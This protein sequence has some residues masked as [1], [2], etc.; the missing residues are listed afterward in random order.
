V[1][2]MDICVLAWVLDLADYGVGGDPDPRVRLRPRRR[3]ENSGS[4]F[5]GEIYGG[6]ILK[7][8]VGNVIR[9]GNCQ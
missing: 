4:G 1:A 5:Y 9:K 7:P 6:K 3:F 2:R 8:G